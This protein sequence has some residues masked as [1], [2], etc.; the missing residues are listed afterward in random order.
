MRSY[1]REGAPVVIRRAIEVPSSSMR[2]WE[3]L[4]GVERWPSW[5]RGIQSAVLRGDLAPGNS[6]QW[7]ADGMRIASILVECEEGRCIGWTIRTLGARGYQRWTLEELASGGTRVLLEES[8]HGLVVWLLKGT[9]G[10]TL[11]RSRSEWLEGLRREVG[12]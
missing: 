5:H 6:L 8:W 7:R 9:L 1:L 11:N 3:V 10:R 12:N 4:T 2:T